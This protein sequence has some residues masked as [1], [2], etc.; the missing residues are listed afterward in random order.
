MKVALCCAGFLAAQSF[1]I[2]ARL[3]QH[4]AAYP[5]FEELIPVVEQAWARGE[6]TAHIVPFAALNPPGGA[7]Q[8]PLP[9]P[10]FC[11]TFRSC[12]SAFDLP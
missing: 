4:A 3:Q 1:A 6:T 11:E 8:V 10:F 9:L 12:S 7:P 2:P 5:E